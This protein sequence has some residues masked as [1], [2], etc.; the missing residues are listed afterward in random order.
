MP[1]SKRVQITDEVRDLFQF[2]NSVTN[3]AASTAG[4]QTGL[5][6][7][8][9]DWSLLQVYRDDLAAALTRRLVK[10]LKA[11]ILYHHQACD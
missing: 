3:V 4:C 8:Y 10:L 2:L 1:V 7:L 5:S 11:Q 9:T 6:R